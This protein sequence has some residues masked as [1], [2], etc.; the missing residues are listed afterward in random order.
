MSS[1]EIK[2]L[3]NEI[4]TGGPNEITEVLNE[5][6]TGYPHEFIGRPITYVKRALMIL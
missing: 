2:R 5:I 3:S 6:F 4:F 1:D